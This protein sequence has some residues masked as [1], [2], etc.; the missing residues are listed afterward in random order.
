MAGLQDG[1]IA[2][3]QDCRR[4]RNDREGLRQY[5]S[6]VPLRAAPS[7]LP[8]CNFAILPSCN[9]AILQ[10]SHLADSEYYDIV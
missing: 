10:L 2:G 4:G 6:E 8:S 7:I 5:S 1:R 3:W 9:P